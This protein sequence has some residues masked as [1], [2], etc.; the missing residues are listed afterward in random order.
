MICRPIEKGNS[1]LMTPYT[2]KTASITALTTPYKSTPSV[3][4]S[5]AMSTKCPPS[6]SCQSV[7][8]ISHLHATYGSVGFNPQVQLC[9]QVMEIL[10]ACRFR[11]KSAPNLGQSTAD[12]PLFRNL[13]FPC[14]EEMDEFE[15]ML[16]EDFMRY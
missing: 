11:P 6:Q 4:T 16:Q 3:H 5:I 8:N 7:A 1:T 15:R 12:P 10:L 14:P 9:Q 13:F 2:M